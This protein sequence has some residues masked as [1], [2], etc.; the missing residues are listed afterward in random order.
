[1]TAFFSDSRR[2]V[3]LHPNI[4]Q[5]TEELDTSRGQ[6]DMLATL[7]TLQNAG[8]E[9]SALINNYFS[10]ESTPKGR[11]HLLAM[12]QLGHSQS[13]VL[14]KSTD[15]ELLATFKAIELYHSSA[16]GGTD[17]PKPEHR[18]RIKAIVD[19]APDEWKVWTKKH[20]RDKNDKPLIQKLEEVIE[21]GDETGATVVDSWPGFCKVAVQSRNEIAHGK[22]SEDLD[23]GLRYHA[24]SMGLRWVLRHVYLRR[25]GVTKRKTSQIVAASNGFRQ[26][27]RTLKSWYQESSQAQD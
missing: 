8:L 10:L 13:R 9:F 18:E 7:A 4:L 11:K 20:L 23:A 15:A 14:D 12:H 19:G 25:L 24:M 6:L 17:I 21:R 1:M 26:E 5:S 27:M 3:I 16:I 2:S 22:V